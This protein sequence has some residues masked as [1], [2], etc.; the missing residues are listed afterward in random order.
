LARLAIIEGGHRLG[1]FMRYI[2][3]DDRPVTLQDVRKA[4]AE[5]GAGYELD[6]EEAECTIAYEGKSIG[7]ITL[8]IPG[9]GLF[10]EERDELIEFAEDGDGPSKPRVVDTLRSAH[11]IVAVQVL[12]GDGDTDRTL[13]AL[14][15]LWIWLQANRRGLA[16]A[17][18]EG[19]YDGENLI[20]A[21][22]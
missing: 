18:G 6:G 22:E 9:D 8:N 12:F 1:Y 15:P 10:D 2:V 5:A 11:G 21:L 4:F 17:D 13:D 20:L 19:Y 16:Q 7:Q 14:S 3:S